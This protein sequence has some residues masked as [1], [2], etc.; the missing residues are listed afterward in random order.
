LFD[1]KTDY[2]QTS[3]LSD[4]A[5]EA[6]MTGLLVAAMVRAEAPPEQYQRLGLAAPSGKR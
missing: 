6:R 4:P 5:L 1:L 3:V 2:G